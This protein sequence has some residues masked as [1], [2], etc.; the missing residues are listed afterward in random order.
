MVRTLALAPAGLLVHLF[1]LMDPELSEDERREGRAT[2]ARL[3]ADLGAPA[4]R[5][6][7]PAGRGSPRVASSPLAAVGSCVLARRVV[8]DL[9]T[10]VNGRPDHPSSRAAQDLPV[11]L[12][13]PCRRQG[14][15]ASHIGQGR[16]AP[17]RLTLVQIPG[18]LAPLSDPGPEILAVALSP[19]ARSRLDLALGS[20]DV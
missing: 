12:V 7:R 13:V 18:T 17:P 5:T 16:S 9:S 20:R 8:A 11:T 19:A 15:S 2:F 10:W 3:C 1:D 6:P 14:G 4:S